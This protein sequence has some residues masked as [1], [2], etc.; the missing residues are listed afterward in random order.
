MKNWFLVLAIV[1]A[2]LIVGCSSSGAGGSGGSSG[3]FDYKEVVLNTDYPNETI[4]AEGFR[5]FTFVAGSNAS[6]TIAL[7][8]LGSD[9]DWYLYD[10]QGNADTLS[11]PIFESMTLSTVDETNTVSLSPGNRYWLVVEEWDSINS[12]FDLRISN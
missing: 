4:N 1:S 5:D 10:D 8:N 6:H 12:S 11:F 9:V 2:T 3:G 7:T